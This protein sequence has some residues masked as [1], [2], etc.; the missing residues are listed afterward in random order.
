M[1]STPE[2]ARANLARFALEHGLTFEEAGEVGFGR[3]CVGFTRDGSYVAHNP[4]RAD[5]FEPITEYADARLYPPEAVRDAYHKHDCLAVLAH[6][7]YAAA[8]VQLD[9]W[10]RHLESLGR[11]RVVEYETGA[12]GLQAAFSGRTGWTVRVEPAS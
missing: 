5:T 8:M 3:P 12:T 11:V 6:N 4:M 1:S 2:E 10:V 9:T 7:E